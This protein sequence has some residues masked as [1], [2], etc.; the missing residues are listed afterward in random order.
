[1]SAV[2]SSHKTIWAG[3]IL[4]VDLSQGL[5]TEQPTSD[6]ISYAIG[7]RGIGQ[8]I[9]FRELDPQV[10]AYDPENILVLG[11]GPLVGTMAPSGNRLSVD[12]KNPLT[13]GVCA[14]NAGG[15]FAPELK[16]AG[17]DSIVISGKSA[18]PV[19]LWI[20][21]GQA[22]LRDASHLWGF[23]TW[24]TE[25]AVRNELGDPRV[26]LV[27]IGPAGENRVRGACLIVD[28]AR[29]A[30]RGGAGA[31]MGSKRLKAVAV[32]GTGTLSPADDAAFMHAVERCN[33]KI[34]HSS[35]IEV[36]RAGGSMRFA[37]AGG[38]DGNLPQ[39]VRNYQDCFWPLHKSRKIYEPA[40]KEG[41]EVR[42]LGCFNCPINC[43]HFYTV[44]EG[45]YRGSC[46]EGFEI[47][48]GRGFGSNLDIDYPPA[49]IEAH[50]YCS[51]MGLDVDIASAC[52]GFAFEAYDRGD[53]SREE[54]NGLDLIW[55]N[56]EAAIE[57]LHALVERRGIGDMLAE[58]VKSASETLGRGSEAYAL[59]VKGA[60]LNEA[61]MRPMKAWAL[62]IVLSTH[63]GGHLDGAPGA[64]AWVDQEE[65]AK[66][67][68]GNP[69][70]GA[71]GDYR[72]QA[73]VVIW[74][75]NYKAVIDMLGIC[76][77]TSMWIDSQALSPDDYADLL[78]AGSG[79]HFTGEE[80]MHLGRNLHQVQ[81][82]FNTLH[83]GFTRVDDHPPQ[84]L[85][86]PAKSGP[87]TGERL[88]PEKWED[89]LDEYYRMNHWDLE[90]GWQTAESLRVTGLN[91]VAAKLKANGR[92]KL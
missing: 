91:E 75:E 29:A 48:S 88:D 15:H 37:G 20:H 58:G 79:R 47:N 78:S 36:Y 23:D 12:T 31:V 34:G 24:Q 53:L 11:A 82:A 57:L 26:R 87:F 85:L 27:S 92:L 5:I 62:G 7:G 4:R 84:R 76:Y 8:W 1:M 38:L 59:Q 41:Y 61:A 2:V 66:E 40:L 63:G 17:Y 73:A 45:P 70:P 90:T 33:Q 32:R 50:N 60:D 30:G 35:I 80:L 65:L 3:K 25:T 46:G 44:Q 9:L 56:H 83:T 89:M 64:W 77:F 81:K 13:G 6:Y 67:I 14:S 19:Y 18:T 68:F 72:N 74:F 22:E 49:I 86:E 51:R 71:A 43:S 42:R 55:G 69:H 52:L 21:D 28:R 16:W 10:G 39:G 54:A